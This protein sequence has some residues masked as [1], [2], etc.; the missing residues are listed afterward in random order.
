MPS[1]GR[2]GG[3]KLAAR[4]IAGNEEVTKGKALVACRPAQHETSGIEM[5]TEGC[6]K[7][8]CAESPT[9]AQL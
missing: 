2:K 3:T 9:L 1:E 5:W 7:G 4:E 6:S 8:L